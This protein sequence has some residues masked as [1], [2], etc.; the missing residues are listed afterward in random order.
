MHKVKPWH[1]EAIQAYLDEEHKAQ[2]KA[3][4]G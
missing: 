4:R 3:Q 1:M 2:M